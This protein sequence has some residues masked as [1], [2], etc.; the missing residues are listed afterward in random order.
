MTRFGAIEQSWQVLQEPSPRGSYARRRAAALAGASLFFAGLL[1]ALGLG[2]LVLLGFAAVVAL[3]AAVAGGR[4]LL[5]ARAWNRIPVAA[6]SAR[7]ASVA[8]AV[9]SRRS[10]GRARPALR[11][12]ASS[13]AG[14]ARTARDNLSPRLSVSVPTARE[15]WPGIER[16]SARVEQ[17]SHTVRPWLSA[18][19]SALQNRTR[20]LGPLVE[21]LAARARA[22]APAPGPP[23]EPAPVDRQRHALQLNAEG[24][25]LRREG[26]YDEAARQH[27]A[28]LEIFRELGD[29]R[30]E[31][32]TLN[33]VALAKGR[34]G[35]EDAAVAQF[36]EA[37]AILRELADPQHEAQVT[38]NLG[39]TLRRHGHDDRAKELLETALEKLDPES[40]AARQV[41]LQLRR[42]S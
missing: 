41:E 6:R 11:R 20:E 26:A 29:R 37:L 7:A 5:R 21:R 12:L 18:R 36:E 31:A 27:A 1:D 38:A 10:F 24:T 8:F 42:A 14:R 39:I 25:R 15:V 23:P 34:A 33:N 30:A 17:T 40:A 16:V 3:A 13:A 32:L 4:L 19:I 2:H 35:D 22:A 9:S 28:A